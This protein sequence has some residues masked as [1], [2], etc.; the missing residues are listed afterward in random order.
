[1]TVPTLIRAHPPGSYADVL[2]HLR[3]G[4]AAATA[5]A[6]LNPE[7]PQAARLSW[8]RGRP[9]LFCGDT[10]RHAFEQQRRRL[11]G[12]IDALTHCLGHLPGTVRDRRA[13]K[14]ALAQRQWLLLRYPDPARQRSGGADPSP[15]RGRRSTPAK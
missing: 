1:M 8:G 14:G 10:C 11:L 4:S 9:Q 6:C 7:C 15:P 2:E 12:E 3:I 13:L 5:A